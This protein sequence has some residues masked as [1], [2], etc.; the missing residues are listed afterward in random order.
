MAKK[1]PH[2]F[3]IGECFGPVKTGPCQCGDPACTDI[4]T[5]REVRLRPDEAARLFRM[6]R[7]ELYRLVDAGMPKHGRYADSHFIWSEIRDWHIAYVAERAQKR[8]GRRC[9]ICSR[10]M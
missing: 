5:W 10:V 9:A 2:Y 3:G 6:S 4:V 1:D 8:R 7:R